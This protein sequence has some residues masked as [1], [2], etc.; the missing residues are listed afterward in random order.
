MA[1]GPNI[2]L[3][4]M[5]VWALMTQFG[6]GMLS[7]LEFP[8]I[9][10]LISSGLSGYQQLLSLLSFPASVW[11][12][13]GVENMTSKKSRSKKSNDFGSTA[14]RARSVRVAASTYG[15]PTGVLESSKAFFRTMMDPAHMA[16][17]DCN[18]IPD[19]NTRPVLVSKTVSTTMMPMTSWTTFV[20]ANGDKVSAGSMD[21]FEIT[22]FY[23]IQDSNSCI[24]YHVVAYG[25]GKWTEGSSAKKAVS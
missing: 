24:R 9:S 16:D 17:Y 4:L 15:M 3:M 22:K 14:A 8:L 5:H 23:I 20:S 13:A 21:S 11:R 1:S 10:N 25:T 2:W 6:R 12:P 7:Y 18:G 19:E